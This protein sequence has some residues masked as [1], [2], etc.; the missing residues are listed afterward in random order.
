MWKKI[1][2][3]TNLTVLQISGLILIILIYPFHWNTLYNQPSHCSHKMKNSM[4]HHYF[5]LYEV[6][7]FSTVL[8]VLSQLH[9]FSHEER[10][11][12]FIFFSDGS[13][14]KFDIATEVDGR[15]KQFFHWA[16]DFSSDRCST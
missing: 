1:V 13:M 15:E 3:D 10:G 2:G 8:C 6:P 5:P 14:K 16:L 7:L 11:D 4:Y 12:I 9:F